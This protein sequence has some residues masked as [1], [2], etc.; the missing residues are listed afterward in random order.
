MKYELSLY[1]DELAPQAAMQLPLSGALGVIRAV[2]VIHGGL[3]VHT[4]N[5]SGVLGGN[6]A[7]HTI[8]GAQFCAGHLTTWALRW[9]FARAGAPDAAASGAGVIP[10]LFQ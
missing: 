8:D 9:E 7:F 3:R 5:F 4:H 6:S 2:Y 1:K 10:F